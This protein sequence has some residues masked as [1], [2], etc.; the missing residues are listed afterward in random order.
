MDETYISKEDYYLCDTFYC[1]LNAIEWFEDKIVIGLL[2]DGT[3][4]FMVK[5]KYNYRVADYTSKERY[6]DGCAIYWSDISKAW[7]LYDGEQ[8]Y[9]FELPEEIY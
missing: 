6:T 2:E 1:F 8:C 3:I 9:S 5:E 7:E 4:L